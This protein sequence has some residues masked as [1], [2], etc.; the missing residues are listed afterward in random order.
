M[1]CFSQILRYKKYNTPSEVFCS[2]QITGTPLN[3]AGPTLP[4]AHYWQAYS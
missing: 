1:E 4:H 3:T 2:V